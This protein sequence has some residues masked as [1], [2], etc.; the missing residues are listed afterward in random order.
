MRTLV[1]TARLKY[2]RWLAQVLALMGKDQTHMTRIKAT[3]C[4]PSEC[5]C[6][7][8]AEA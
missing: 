2:G 1:R 6:L 4:A 7:S 5:S 8:C 3:A